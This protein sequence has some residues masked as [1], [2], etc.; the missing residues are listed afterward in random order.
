MDSP[1]YRA[2]AHQLQSARP[3]AETILLLNSTGSSAAKAVLCCAGQI[4]QFRNQLI[5]W[6]FCSFA[7]F[8]AVHIYWSVRGTG[9]PQYVLPSVLLLSGIGLDA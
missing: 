3:G 4:H 7:R 9:G 1:N 5:L 8:W 2:R 6:S